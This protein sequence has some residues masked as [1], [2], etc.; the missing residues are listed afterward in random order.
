MSWYTEGT[1]KYFIDYNVI[2]Q[3]HLS[4]KNLACFDLD[5]TLIIYEKCFK[6]LLTA[7]ANTIEVLRELHRQGFYIVVFSNQGTAPWLIKERQERLQDLIRVSGVPITAFFAVSRKKDD[8]YRKPQIGMVQ[9]CYRLLN[10]VNPQFLGSRTFY[11]GDAIGP[12]SPNRWFVFR[13]N[14]SELALNAKLP[15]LSPDQ[16][17]TEFPRP[18]IREGTQLIMTIG[19]PYSG[20]DLNMIYLGQ[21]ID[22]GKPELPLIVLDDNMVYAGGNNGVAGIKGVYYVLGQHPTQAI[23]NE[24]IRRLNVDPSRVEYHLYTRSSYDP[25]LS[26]GSKE[27]AD[28]Y[29]APPHYIRCN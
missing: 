7:Y 18:I 26:V 9:L 28:S 22:V 16:I 11:C 2:Q 19:L 6:G 3:G 20:W 29:Q 10:V 12:T 13:T 21:V 1:C 14:D 8:P 23:R 24:I 25:N 4:V 17:F 27:F 5:S 15:F